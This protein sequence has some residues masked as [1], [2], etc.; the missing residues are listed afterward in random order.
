MLSSQTVIL[1]HFWISVKSLGINLEHFL[2]K[3]KSC[4]KI[5]RTWVEIPVAS[6]NSTKLLLGLLSMRPWMMEMFSGILWVL[7]HLGYGLSPVSSQPFRNLLCQTRTCVFDIVWSAHTSCRA[8]QQSIGEHPDLTKNFSV[9]RCSTLGLAEALTRK[10]SSL[11][12]EQNIMEMC[13]TTPKCIRNKATNNS[14]P[15]LTEAPVWQTESD[16]SGSMNRSATLTDQ[17]HC[18][19]MK[20]KVSGTFLKRFGNFAQ[21]RSKDMDMERGLKFCASYQVV[22]CCEPRSGGFCFILDRRNQIFPMQTLHPAGQGCHCMQYL[23]S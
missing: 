23:S 4:F 20:T 7:G 5:L 13:K 16:L 8:L 2:W 6:A 18:S 3:P 9:A 1:V 19:E 21:N 15:N 17:A 10:M 11:N 12:R 22:H 14:R